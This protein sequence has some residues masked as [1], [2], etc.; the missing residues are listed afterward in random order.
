MEDRFPTRARVINII[1]GGIASGG[2]SNSAR[3]SYA[4]SV[5]ICPIQ[6]KKRNSIEVLLLV[7]KT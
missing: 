2:D 3:K 4:R 5:G 1:I 7:M 6:K